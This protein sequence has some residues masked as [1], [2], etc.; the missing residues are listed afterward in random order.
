MRTVR[1]PRQYL[2]RHWFFLLR[3]FLRYSHTRDAFVLRLVGNETGPVLRV[4]RRAHAQ[5]PF[6]GVERRRARPA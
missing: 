4:D 5:A 2:A 6:E 1:R 3:P